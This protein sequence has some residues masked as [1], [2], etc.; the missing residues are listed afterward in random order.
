MLG[1]QTPSN[2]T[3]NIMVDLQV[4][5]FEYFVLDNRYS[6]AVDELHVRFDKQTALTYIDDSTLA[7]SA[8]FLMGKNPA[9]K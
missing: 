7:K 5:C 6:V 8:H 1:A 4:L 2:G 9:R 3:M